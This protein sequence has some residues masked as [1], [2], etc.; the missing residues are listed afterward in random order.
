M[1]RNA[2]LAVG[3]LALSAIALGANIARTHA[4]VAFAIE[5]VPSFYIGVRLTKLW[6]KEGVA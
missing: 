6:L 4:A 3:I 2:H 1:S 5:F